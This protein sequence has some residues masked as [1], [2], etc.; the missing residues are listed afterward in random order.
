MALLTAQMDQA[1][2]TRVLGYLRRRV[3]ALL[4]VP[5]GNVMVTITLGD[6]RIGI[7]AMSG[8]GCA[9]STSGSKAAALTDLVRWTNDRC[10]EMAE[11]LGSE[12]AMKTT[13]APT[14][15]V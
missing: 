10:A 14:K 13:A 15:E 4:K 2:T 5:A 7:A 6:D 11:Q 12:A 1:A 8:D 3:P 9:A